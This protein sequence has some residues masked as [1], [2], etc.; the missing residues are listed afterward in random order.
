MNDAMITTVKI[1]VKYEFIPAV[2]NA[3]VDGRFDPELLQRSILIA[4]PL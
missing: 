1:I 2:T 4:T 3:N